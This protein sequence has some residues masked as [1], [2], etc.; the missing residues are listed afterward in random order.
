MDKK[1]KAYLLLKNNPEMLLKDIDKELGLDDTVRKWKSREFKE[2]SLAEKAGLKI[3]EKTK[4]KE[5]KAYNKSQKNNCDMTQ[6]KNVTS[7]KQSEMSQKKVVTSQKNETEIV[8]SQKTEEKNATQKNEVEKEFISDIVDE[9][10]EEEK[11]RKTYKIF[12]ERERMFLTY[13][14]SYKFN[15]KAASLAVGYWSELEGYRMLNKPKI[16]KVIRRIK[17]II[18]EKS[19]IN[20]TPDDLMEE[21]FLVLKKAHGEIPQNK[22]F[23][24]NKFEK[25]II[26]VSLRLEE[27]N[28]DGTVSYKE[29][30]KNHTTENSWQE[31]EEHSIRDTD[32]K[33]ANI[34]LKMISDLYGYMDNSKL[35]REKFEHEKTKDKEIELEEK[36]EYIED[37]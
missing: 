4:W 29:V 18:F 24:V 17:T 23:L 25:E 9:V 26:P 15:V 37:V 14:F 35:A 36:I 20:F 11:A 33:A 6:K 22:T 32:L 16:R 10:I 2:I 34:A 19:G 13:Y 28:K 27:K 3:T 8:A 5:V 7:Q 21:L 30:A 1:I 31:P 12:T